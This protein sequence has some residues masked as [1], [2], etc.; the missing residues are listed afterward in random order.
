MRG[1]VP[2]W[3]DDGGNFR[4]LNRTSS[5]VSWYYPTIAQAL[6]NCATNVTAIAPEP[7]PPKENKISLYGLMEKAGVVYYSLPGTAFVSLRVYTLQ[8]RIAATLVK[9]VQ[10]AG[11]Y[12]V[13]L[14]AKG[15]SFGNYILEL[16]AGNNSVT[17]RLT[18]IQ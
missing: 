18:I 11:N 1:M 7:E 2:V 8:G 9:S 15:I 6:C 5:P 17:K 12:E 10:S 3:W 4:I 14:P 16:K 13:K